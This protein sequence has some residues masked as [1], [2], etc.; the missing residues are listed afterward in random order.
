MDDPDGYEEIL[1]GEHPPI[2]PGLA[3][4][5]EDLDR[6]IIAH[7]FSTACIHDRHGACPLQCPTCRSRCR[8]RCHASVV[9]QDEPGAFARRE[10][11]ATITEHRERTD[12]RR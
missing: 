7:Y 10:R 1:F 8:C 4:A 9:G 2:E 3:A 6:A 12:G 5:D 11:L